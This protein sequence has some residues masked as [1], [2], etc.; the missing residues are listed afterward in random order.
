MNFT[1][2]LD[3]VHNFSLLIALVVACQII[4]AR[5]HVHRLATRILYGLL[6]GAVGLVSMMTPVPFLPGIIF[7]GRSIVLSTGAFLG[8]PVVGL[9][10]GLLCGAYRL[11]LGGDGT[12]MGVSV[13]L[14]SV[15]LGAAF[16]LWRRR[17]GRPPRTR[18][19]WAFGLLVHAIMLAMIVLLPGSARQ[20]TWHALSLPILGLYPIATLLVLRLFLDYEKQQASRIALQQ[21]QALFRRSSTASPQPSTCWIAMAFLCDGTPAFGISCSGK[22]MRRFWD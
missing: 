8:G 9:I 5:W 10:S 15:A 22:P 4:E 11:W 14:E 18:T 13:I 20:A 3:L 19:L 1:L 6:F 12:A 17:S 21:E 7:D 2:L 16:Y